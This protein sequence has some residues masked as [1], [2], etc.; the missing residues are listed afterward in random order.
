MRNLLVF[1]LTMLFCVIGIISCSNN[2][3]S[4]LPPGPLKPKTQ[5]EQIA[6]PFDYLKL[7]KDQRAHLQCDS[8]SDE[9]VEQLTR[10]F[11]IQMGQ[12]KTL[13]GK[14][15]SA[16]VFIASMKYCIPY[17]YPIWYHTR[18]EVNPEY[19]Y[20]GMFMEKGLFLRPININGYSY[21]PWGCPYDS[22]PIR[23]HWPKLKNLGAK[24][25]NGFTCSQ[26]VGWCL[27]NGGIN[28]YGNEVLYS[29]WAEDLRKYPG[30]KEV[31]LKEGYKT[32]RPGD[33][34]GFQGHIALV[35]GVE[36]K[37]VIFISADGG[38]DATWPGH[39]V[40]WH[41]FDRY[42]TDYNTYQYKFIVQMAGVY[43]D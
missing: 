13:R 40:R 5:D 10:D 29:K 21:K 22:A 17:A 9:E 31:L 37:Y 42:G 32:I 43:N 4:P 39:G 25:D 24:A 38:S 28:K 34:I 20:F 35:I 7:I 12:A 23:P 3:G 11:D 16:G 30:G 14:V 41:V 1:Y 36:G 27:I 15:V 33:L 2:E 19:R 18:P 6:I 8:Y 26:V